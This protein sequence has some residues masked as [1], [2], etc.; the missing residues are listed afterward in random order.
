M[1]G[2]PIEC[3]TYL[4]DLADWFE[5]ELDKGGVEVQ[6]AG[7]CLIL[8]YGHVEMLARQLRILGMPPEFVSSQEPAEGESDDDREEE[9]D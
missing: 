7:K 6:G 8:P 2:M 4:G 1:S 3:L 5:Q 9:N